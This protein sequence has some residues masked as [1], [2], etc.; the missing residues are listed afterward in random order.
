MPTGDP[1][2]LELFHRA[3]KQ[4]DEQAWAVIEQQ[5]RGLLLSWLH[6]H[7]AARLALE[8]ESPQSCIS[9]ALST[10][11][12]AT[13]SSTRSEPVF[14]TLAEILAS[15][16]RCLK[17]VVL[18]AVRKAQAL[19]HEVDRASVAGEGGR[20]TPA[21]PGEDLWEAL[22]R[23]LPNKQERL[24]VYLRYVCGERP[25]DLVADHPQTFPSVEAVSRLER[26]VLDR[27]RRHPALAPWKR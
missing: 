2:G 5:W 9:A 24:L 4:R 15:L 26:K 25:R 22:E 16:Q 10:F 8:H 21:A 11:W 7:P 1:A 17:S 20:Q 23:A 19:Q 3:I 13:T 18:D 27:L 12:Q 6:R 14:A